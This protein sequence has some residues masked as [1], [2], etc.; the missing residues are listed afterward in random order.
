MNGP[1][2]AALAVLALMVIAT[3]AAAQPGGE[4]LIL[5]LPAGYVM[6][7]EIRHEG[8]VWTEYLPRGQKPEDWSDM[9]SVTID[10]GGVGMDTREYERRFAETWAYACRTAR[11][12]TLIAGRQNGYRVRVAQLSCPEPALGGSPEWLLVKLLEGND[13]FYTV[14]RIFR[15]RPNAS[16]LRSWR[17]FLEGVYLCDNRIAGRECPAAGQ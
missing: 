17:E 2:R 1:I 13:S 10:L 5:R 6:A 11:H 15:D 7:H 4:T 8:F 3:G 9:L 14:Q 16:T 12:E